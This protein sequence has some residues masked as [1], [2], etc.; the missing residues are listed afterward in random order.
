MVETGAMLISAIIIGIVFA[1]GIIISYS[2]GVQQG[3]ELPRDPEIHKIPQ[4]ELIKT[5]IETLKPAPKGAAYHI[6]KDRVAQ[7]DG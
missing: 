7:F 4:P 3:Y 2:V 1:I 6:S 5:V